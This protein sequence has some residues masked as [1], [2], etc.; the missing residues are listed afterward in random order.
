MRIERFSPEIH[1]KVIS[2]WWEAHKWP[3]I[4]LDV[5]PPT[6]FVAFD[7]E[8]AGAVW[9]YKTDSII[10]WP[11]WM[12]V[13]PHLPRNIRDSAIES[14]LDAVLEEAQT[15]GFKQIF[16]FVKSKHTRYIK[17]LLNREC[18]KADEGTI[19]VRRL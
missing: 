8:P 9:L 1:Y 6:G 3:V 14:L 18:F 13:N 15:Q 16:T 17:R 12:V 5:L 4:P 2:E 11:E 10:C 19:Y 7:G